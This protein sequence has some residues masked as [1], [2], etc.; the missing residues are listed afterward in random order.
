MCFFFTDN[1]LCNPPTPG[2]IPKKDFIG[3]H[4][5]E[6]PPQADKMYRLIANM[7][8]ELD[9]MNNALEDALAGA[10]PG[11]LDDQ[12]YSSAKIPFPVWTP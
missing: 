5:N 1:L 3:N 6:L 10:R 8:N 11:Y 9:Q 12:T 4:P 7:K 2:C